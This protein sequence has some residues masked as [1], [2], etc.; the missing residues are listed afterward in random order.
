MIKCQ[1]KILG[2]KILAIGL[3]I[4]SVHIILG[5]IRKDP[6]VLLHNYYYLPKEQ[7]WVATM[8]S[9]LLV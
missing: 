9:S 8:S 4:Q 3:R 5:I 1:V 6:H 2:L 7:F